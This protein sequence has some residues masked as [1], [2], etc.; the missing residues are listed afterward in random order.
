MRQ[1]NHLTEILRRNERNKIIGADHLTMIWDR[2]ITTSDLRKNEIEWIY[3]TDGTDT[4]LTT[5][6]KRMNRTEIDWSKWIS[7]HDFGHRF[8]RDFGT[9]H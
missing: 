8:D 6:V 1:V 3:H 5:V 7:D 9:I 2:K 4:Y